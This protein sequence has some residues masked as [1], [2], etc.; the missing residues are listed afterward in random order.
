MI[1][2]CGWECWQPLLPVPLRHTKRDKRH[3]FYAGYI[4]Y[5]NTLTQHHNLTFHTSP[6]D[7]TKTVIEKREMGTIE[8]SS[9]LYCTL[10]DICPTP[11]I[12]L[13]S[14]KE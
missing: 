1:K 3:Y 11:I 9:P 14:F 13:H 2:R 6:L 10:E 5:P 7:F 12:M 4:L 8:F